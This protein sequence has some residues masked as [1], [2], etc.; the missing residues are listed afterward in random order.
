MSTSSAAV[1]STIGRWRSA[2][3]ESAWIL[4][5][6]ELTCAAT[7]CPHLPCNS[8][9]RV[10][11]G[12]QVAAVHELEAEASLDAKVAVGDLDIKRR[13]DLDDSV[14]LDVK[15]ERAAHAAIGADGVGRVCRDSSHCPALRSSYSLRNIKAPVGQTPMQLPQ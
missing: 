2:L 15:R 3:I 13:G 5:G 8:G 11:L 10:C 12:L 4:V 7:V 6:F 9:F 14:V 1:R